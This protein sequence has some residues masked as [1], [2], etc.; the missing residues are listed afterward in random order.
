M[1]DLNSSPSI[2]SVYEGQQSAVRLECETSE[3]FPVTKGVR[4]GCMYTVPTLVQL[5]W[6]E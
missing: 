2:R 4:Q 3:W 5:I 6:K 1:V